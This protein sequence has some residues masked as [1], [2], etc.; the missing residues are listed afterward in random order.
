MS[1]PVRFSQLVGLVFA[2]TGVA[3]YLTGLTVLGVVATAFALAAALLNAA[4]GFCPGGETYAVI[5]RIRNNKQGAF[6]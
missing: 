2:V 4:F 3:G 1:A 5:T 6:A